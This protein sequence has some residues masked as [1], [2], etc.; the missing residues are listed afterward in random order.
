MQCPVVSYHR[1]SFVYVNS[2]Y[3]QGFEAIITQ[4]EFFVFFYNI[5]V[6]KTKNS[7]Q[8]PDGK[9]FNKHFFLNGNY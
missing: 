2:P 4:Y 8:T 6:A 1:T 3:T 7:A 5:L 9:H